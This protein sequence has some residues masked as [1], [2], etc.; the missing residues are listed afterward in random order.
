MNS[1]LIV[2]SIAVGIFAFLKVKWS[3][4]KYRAAQNALLAMTV[5]P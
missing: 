2:A 5:P 1:V 4:Q 3:F